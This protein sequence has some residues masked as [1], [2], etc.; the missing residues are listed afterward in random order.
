MARGLPRAVRIYGDGPQISS[1]C[2]AETRT[3]VV[4]SL[5]G[6]AIGD[7]LDWQVSHWRGIV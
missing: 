2:V 6:G 4:A 3:P 7:T 1:Y 5:S